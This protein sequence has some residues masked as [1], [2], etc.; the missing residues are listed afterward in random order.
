ML[1][2]IMVE[3]CEQQV[4]LR[5]HDTGPGIEPEVL[6]HVFERF[7]RGTASR[8]GVGAGLG[9]AIARTLAEAQRGRL[10][11]ESETGR[12]STFTLWLPRSTEA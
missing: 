4:A 2:S 3:P 9:L 10:M 6:P 12:G 7:V 5:V 11:A 8:T 1:R